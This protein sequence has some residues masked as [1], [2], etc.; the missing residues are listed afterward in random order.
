MIKKFLSS[1][2]VYAG[3][4]LTFSIGRQIVFLPALNKL[5]PELFKEISF[6]IVLL[7]FLVY[8]MGASVADYYVKQVNTSGK[9]YSL[10]KYLLHF[11]YLSLVSFL[12]F[13]FYNIS[14]LI[15]L[16][17]AIY[18]LFYVLN[19]LQ[20]KLFFN[21]LKF[22][23]NYTYVF[24]RLVPYISLL[25]Y[26]SIVGIRSF[27][28]FSLSLLIFEAI[29]YFTFKYQLSDA[30]KIINNSKTQKDYN[31][32]NFMGIYLLFALT[33][34]LDMFV[35]EYLF[36]DKF[37]EYYQ[38]ISVYMIFINPIILLTSSSLLS[39]LTHIEHNTIIKNKIKILLSILLISLISGIVF[40]IFGTTFISILYPKNIMITE[41]WF[42]SFIVIFTSL[43]FLILKTFIIKLSSLKDMI[44]INL[45]IL[46]IPLIFYFK[47]IYFISAF[48]ITR[49]IIITLFFRIKI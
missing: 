43:F 4:A 12:I 21:D 28:F 3:S 47:F 37:A 31:I 44:S 42:L 48:Y 30:Y 22:S 41:Y 18:M 17:L 39:I 20:I 15:S 19:T 35:V 11:S 13:Y 6:F 9:N 24:L 46:I 2:L 16:I 14:L 34:R 10:Y 40:Q 27:L 7:D 49:F 5:S 36:N 1:S 45:L 8:S 23:K 26:E 38:I 25:I 33:L 32:F 29:A